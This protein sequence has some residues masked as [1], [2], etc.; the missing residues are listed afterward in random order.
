MVRNLP[1]AI[2][3]L[4]PLFMV[5]YV[6]FTCEIL[7]IV[8][9]LFLDD[10]SPETNDLSRLQR[11]N[12]QYGID[13]IARVLIT[14]AGVVFIFQLFGVEFRTLLTSISI[15][16][17]AIAIISKDYIT[18]FLVGLYFSFSKDFEINDYVRFGEQK[19]KITELQS[20]T[21]RFTSTKSSTTPSGT[22][23]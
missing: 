10:Y 2:R 7:L 6:V 8:A 18:D 4:N 19:G 15:V 13:N 23:A 9:L 1:P 16:A 21:P 11:T 22:F 12:F 14:L 17:A 20:P 3:L 5:R